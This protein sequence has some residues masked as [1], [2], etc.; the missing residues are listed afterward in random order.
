M[1]KTDGDYRI[2]ETFT[3]KGKMWKTWL[4][5]LYENDLQK[6]VFPHLR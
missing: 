5:K 2:G 1:P 3:V 4:G 6:A